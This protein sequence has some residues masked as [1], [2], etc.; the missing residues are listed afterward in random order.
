MRSNPLIVV[1]LVSIPQH[2]LT[3][4]CSIIEFDLNG[5]V[6][7]QWNFHNILEIVPNRKKDKEV[8]IKTANENVSFY[9]LCVVF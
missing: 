7:E 1:V 4:F 2:K 8:I 9:Y 6:K 5:V 3:Q